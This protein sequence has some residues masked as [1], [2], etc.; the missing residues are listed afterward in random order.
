MVV[1][2]LK[3]AFYL[4]GEWGIFLLFLIAVFQLWH[5]T[6]FLAY[7]IVGFVINVIINTFLKALFKQP[8]PSNVKD[9][10]GLLEKHGIPFCYQFGFTSD[11]FGMPSGHA[12]TVAFVFVYLF[13]MDKTSINIYIILLCMI[14]L[15]HRVYFQ[16]HTVA[17][18]FVGLLSGS[19]VAY[20]F[21]SICRRKLTGKLIM[22]KDD[23]FFG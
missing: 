5:S 3:S 1:E 17:Q 20:V 15:G 2:M 18:V 23:N 16:Y 13:L 8:R 19:L 22:K 10:K 11:L 9:L 12:Q 4:L 7:F 14:I 6:N 21:Y